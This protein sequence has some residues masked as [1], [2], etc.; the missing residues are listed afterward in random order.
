MPIKKKGGGK[1][2]TRSAK[3]KSGRKTTGSRGRK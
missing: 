2:A 1:G 3:R